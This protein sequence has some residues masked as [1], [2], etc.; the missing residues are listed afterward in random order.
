M[1]VYPGALRIAERS[2]Q[3]GARFAERDI[4]R[5]GRVESADCAVPALLDVNLAG[6][7]GADDCD[8]PGQICQLLLEFRPANTGIA[9]PVLGVPPPPGAM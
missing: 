9:P 8:L 6:A 7:T 5:A 1:P 2:T 4:G 3:N